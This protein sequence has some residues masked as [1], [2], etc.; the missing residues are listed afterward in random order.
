MTIQQT[1]PTNDQTNAGPFARQPGTPTAIS[2]D[3]LRPLPK[4]LDAL[5]LSL[6]ALVAAFFVWATFATIEETTK[7][8]GRIIPASKIQ[9]VQNLEGGI[10]REVL[11]HEGQHV[12]AGDILLRIDPTLA[13]SSHGETHQRIQGLRAL[14]ARLTAEVDG[15]PLTF[16]DDV[17][18]QH[19]N[20]VVHQNN[21]YT[22]RRR[23]LDAAIAT[24]ELQ[25]KQ[26]AQERLELEAK[27]ATLERSLQIARDELAILEPLAE[28]RAVSRSELLRARA[29]VNETEGALSAA[30]LALPRLTDQ[31]LEALSRSREKKAAYRADALSQLAKANIEL[32]ALQET[33]KGEA[34]R[35]SRTTVRAPATGIVKTVNVTTIGQVIK[36]GSDLIEIVPLNDTLLVEARI[37]PKDI[38]F[39]HPGQT[40]IVKLTAYDFSLYGGLEGSLEQISADSTTDDKGDTFYLVRVRTSRNTLRHDS[41]DLRIIPGMIAEV[42][43]LTG[44]KTVLSYLTK[45]L[46]RMRHNALTER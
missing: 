13:G 32:N 17:V 16:P 12:K 39:L 2:A 40:A 23:E 46:T 21:E 30:Q 11:I 41:E 9:V 26:H 20:L 35:L 34:D 33:N 3:L 44:E 10:V 4:G 37:R 27:I 28:R 24:F 14:V 22:E 38:A 31:R 25:A 15:T 19:P 1:T 7:G 45:P 29:K 18:K 8:D 36:P 6:V 5:L 42:N 43:I